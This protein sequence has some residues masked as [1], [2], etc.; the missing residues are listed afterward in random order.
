MKRLSNIERF[1]DTASPISR[2]L[3]ECAGFQLRQGFVG[4]VPAL[5]TAGLAPA[6]SQQKEARGQAPVP[7]SGGKPP[8]SKVTAVQLLAAQP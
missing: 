5:S 1:T 3:V 2:H 7:E 4:Q 6:A 8:H